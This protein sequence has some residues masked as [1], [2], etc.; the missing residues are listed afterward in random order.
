ML[1]KGTVVFLERRKLGG[2]KGAR[3]VLS[4]GLFEGASDGNVVDASH[5]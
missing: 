5:G 4:G 2:D 1:L 3:K